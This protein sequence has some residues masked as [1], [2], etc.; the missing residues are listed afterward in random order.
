[1]MLYSLDYRT[2]KWSV[3]TKVHFIRFKLYF[4]LPRTILYSMGLIKIKGSVSR[5]FTNTNLWV[6][7]REKKIFEYHNFKPSE[8]FWTLQKFRFWSLQT[9]SRFF[10]DGLAVLKNI[11]KKICGAYLKVFDRSSLNFILNHPAPGKIIRTNDSEL[12]TSKDE[13][14]GYL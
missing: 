8:V 4:N 6:S 9:N 14:K 1:M 13:V 3:N 2:I 12:K 7:S 5:G 11:L 10:R